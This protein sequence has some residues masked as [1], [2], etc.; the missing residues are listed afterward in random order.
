MRENMWVT[1]KVKVTRHPC[2]SADN[3]LHSD[4]RW[5]E[6]ELWAKNTQKSLSTLYHKVTKKCYEDSKT[7]FDNDGL[8]G[9]LNIGTICCTET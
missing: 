8:L 6:G 7:G 4:R 5:S 1:L 2:Y 3:F 9:S